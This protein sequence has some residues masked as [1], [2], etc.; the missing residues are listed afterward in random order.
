M[1]K[2]ITTITVIFL[3]FSLSACGTKSANNLSLTDKGLSLIGEVD[4]LAECEEYISLYS[5]SDEIA[6]VIK[7]IAEN[8]YTEPKAVFVIPN[9]DEIVLQSMFYEIKL[10]AEV[11]VMVKSRFALA[12]PT[13]I[14]AMNG[15]INVAATSILNHS[16]SFIYEGLKDTT[17]YLYTYD[18]ANSFMVTFTPNDENI[19]N[20][21]VTVI[22]NEE[23]AKCS[24]A[25]EVM[26]FLKESLNF[27]KVSVSEAPKE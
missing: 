2:I 7:G 12:I 21:N 20:A 16:G 15:T 11:E 26:K 14:N 17:T 3:L 9:L 19:V 6:G 22:V 25:D 4:R 27:E 13:Q 10:P 23:L 18:A 1:K 24:T 8:E 5:A